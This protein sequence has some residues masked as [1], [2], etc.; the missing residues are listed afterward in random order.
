MYFNNHIV[1]I[2]INCLGIM[3][4][5][6]TETSFAVV[7]EP[8]GILFGKPNLELSKIIKTHSPRF[9]VCT[10]NTSYFCHICVMKGYP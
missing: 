5:K 6:H 2:H 1:S 3:H 10:E 4:Q 9:V 7:Q 8:I